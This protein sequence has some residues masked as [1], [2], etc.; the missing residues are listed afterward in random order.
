MNIILDEQPI[1]IKVDLTDITSLQRLPKRV[2]K[3]RTY[4]FVENDERDP[5]YVFVSEHYET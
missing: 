2:R 1:P 5:H 3:V 4:A